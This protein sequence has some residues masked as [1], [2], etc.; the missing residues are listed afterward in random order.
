MDRVQRS[1]LITLSVLLLTAVGAHFIGSRPGSEA[2]IPDR[3]IAQDPAAWEGVKF[4]PPEQRDRFVGARDFVRP[5]VRHP[6]AGGAGRNILVGIDDPPEPP[7]LGDE[8]LASR[9]AAEQG[10]LLSLD[11]EPKSIPVIDSGPAN[12][13]GKLPTGP[14]TGRDPFRTA[15]VREKDNLTK[16]AA[17]EL[18]EG[19]R[20]QEIAKLNGL[21]EPYHVQV[22]QLLYLPDALAS[23]A[24]STL[25]DSPKPI[26]ASGSDSAKPTTPRTYKVIA[27]DT[28]SE[29]SQKVYGT[30]VHWKFLLAANGIKK[31]EDMKLGAVLKVPELKD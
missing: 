1:G 19:D 13:S 18:G 8:G 14:G 20:W 12:A 27:G 17:R 21:K 26:E 2:K 3:K 4:L 10:L 7:I 6:L 30:S 16:L 5:P 9:G 28:P 23:S 25:Q 31:A 11:H 29:I 22:G 15:R 24:N